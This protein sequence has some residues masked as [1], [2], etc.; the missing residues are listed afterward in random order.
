VSAADLGSNNAEQQPDEQCRDAQRAHECTHQQ[1]R[2]DDSNQQHAEN[3]DDTMYARRLVPDP[4]CVRFA[5][6]LTLRSLDVLRVT[7]PRASGR[8]QAR[9]PTAHILPEPRTPRPRDRQHGTTQR[10][11]GRYGV[12]YPSIG[13]RFGLAKLTM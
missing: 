10:E 9:R 4:S 1:H 6:R 8:P 7:H 2:Q 3:V 5:G 11:I 13:G 12:P